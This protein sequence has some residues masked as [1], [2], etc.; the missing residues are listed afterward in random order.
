MRSGVPVI[1]YFKFLNQ[2]FFSLS[3]YLSLVDIL[4][5]LLERVLSFLYLRV[6]VDL[7]LP[8]PLKNEVVGSRYLNSRTPFES[9]VT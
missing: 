9:I 8:V 7:I 4:L 5:F 3:S 1:V 2:M 6:P